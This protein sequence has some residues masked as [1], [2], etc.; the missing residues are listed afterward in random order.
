M[1]RDHDDSNRVHAE[2]AQSAHSS[3]NIMIQRFSVQYSFYIRDTD[4]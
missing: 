4:K 2:V 3:N 1:D